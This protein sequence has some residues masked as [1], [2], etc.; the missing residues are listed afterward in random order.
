MSHRSLDA[1]RPEALMIGQVVSHYRVLEK[2][3]GGGMGV[4][5]RAEDT[6]LGRGVALKFLASSLQTREGCLVRALAARPAPLGEI[7]VESRDFR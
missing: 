3:G 4:V 5:Y 7:P 2:L 1:D 6:R